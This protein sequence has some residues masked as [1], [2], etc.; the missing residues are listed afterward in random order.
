[1]A[2][3]ES[4]DSPSSEPVEVRSSTAPERRP[5]ALGWKTTFTVQWAPAEYAPAAQLPPGATTNSPNEVPWLTAEGAAAVP[6]AVRVTVTVSGVD[7]WP[8]GVV[9]G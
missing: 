8:T 2:V 7:V 6:E 3:A 1:M 9:P 5:G 4:R